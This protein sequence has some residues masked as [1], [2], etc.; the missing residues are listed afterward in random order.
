MLAAVTRHVEHVERRI[1]DIRAVPA[2]GEHIGYAD[3]SN[4]Y[5]V[6]ESGEELARDYHSD[7]GADVVEIVPIYRGKSKFAVQ[8]ATEDGDE[9]EIF[10]DADRAQKF[11]ESLKTEEPAE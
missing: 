1:D 9:V 6:H 3:P 5:E 11:A 2:T 7:A 10:E 8:F 4:L